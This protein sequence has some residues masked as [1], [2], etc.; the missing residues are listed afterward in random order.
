M[1]FISNSSSSSF[2]IS[3]KDKDEPIKIEINLLDFIRSCGEDIYTSGL[4]KILKNKKEIDDYFIE[5]YVY[6]DETLDEI[7]EEEQHL[8]KQYNDMLKEVESGNVVIFCDIDYSKTE[9]FE[10]LKSCENI[11]FIVG[12]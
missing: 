8:K 2:V 5:E 12:D 4:D 9:Q 6:D 3:V 11:K 7:F 10:I 1:G